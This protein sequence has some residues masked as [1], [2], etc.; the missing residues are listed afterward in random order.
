MKGSFSRC[1]SQNCQFIFVTFGASLLHT[2]ISE[3]SVIFRG[4]SLK[5][6]FLHLSVISAAVSGAV[7]SD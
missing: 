3:Q 7:A 1:D 2:V 5:L 4:L 6:G